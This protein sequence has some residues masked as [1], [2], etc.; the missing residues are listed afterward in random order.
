MLLLQMMMKMQEGRVGD[1]GLVQLLVECVGGGVGVPVGGQGGLLVEGG[2][3]GGG[4]E[5]GD[6]GGGSLGGL[7]K[8][9]HFPRHF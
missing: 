4:E 5:G 3:G 1:H 8:S 7:Y 2:G 6:G 9:L